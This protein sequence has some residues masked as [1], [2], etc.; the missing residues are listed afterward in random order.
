MRV[1]EAIDPNIWSDIPT[2]KTFALIDPFIADTAWDS[3]TP[4]TLDKLVAS[5]ASIKA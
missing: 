4:A 3:A 1:L 2:L 5:L